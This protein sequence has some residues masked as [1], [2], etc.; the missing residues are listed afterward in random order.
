V[1]GYVNGY[2]LPT[3]PDPIKEDLPQVAGWPPEERLIAVLLLLL[4]LL[5]LLIDL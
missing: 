1:V 5:L 2:I 3:G 4:L